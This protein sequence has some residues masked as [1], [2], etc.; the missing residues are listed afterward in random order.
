MIETSSTIQTAD[1]MSYQ[2]AE[3]NFETTAP[4]DIASLAT[5]T[6][7]VQ[8]TTNVDFT[9][10]TNTFDVSAYQTTNLET[11]TTGTTG[12]DFTATIQSVEPTPTFD[13]S[14]L[15]QATTETTGTTGFDFTTTTQTTTETT[16]TTG[17]DF[18]TTT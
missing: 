10:T 11:T 9:S 14:S 6:P 3:P 15:P 4:F 7:A 12:F 1:T 2:K 18:G 16:G 13:L 17:F 8:E 5:S